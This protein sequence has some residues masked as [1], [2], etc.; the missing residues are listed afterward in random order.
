MSKISTTDLRQIWWAFYWRTTLFGFVGGAILG[1]VVA[2]T[3][4]LIGFPAY[5]TFAATLAGF[6]V[7]AVLTFFM[8]RFALEKKYKTFTVSV[9]SDA[10]ST[11]E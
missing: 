2:V 6:L 3:I 7:N 8:L 1:A 9:G 11:F 10:A 4:K 5:A